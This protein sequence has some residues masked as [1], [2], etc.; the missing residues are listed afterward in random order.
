MAPETGDTY[1][2]E[3]VDEDTQED[4]TH[5]TERPPETNDAPLELAVQAANAMRDSLVNI[6]Y[7]KGCHHNSV[8]IGKVK[9]HRDYEVERRICEIDADNVRDGDLHFSSVEYDD[10]DMLIFAEYRCQDP[11]FAYVYI[12]PEFDGPIYIEFENGLHLSVRRPDSPVLL[13]VHDQPGRTEV[14]FRWIY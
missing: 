8:K 7:T 12:T 2:D 14:L 5:D 13:K 3:I 4:D 9:E 11:S 10:R 1:V 6:G